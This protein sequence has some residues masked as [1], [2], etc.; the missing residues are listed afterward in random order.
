MKKIALLGDSIR[1]YGYGTKVPALLKDEYEVYQPDDNCRYAKYTLRALYDWDVDMKGAEIIHWN[2]GLWDV[3]N[4]YG[5]GPLTSIEDYVRDMLRVHDLLTAR[6]TK[7]IIFATCTPIMEPYAYQDNAR[8]RA[9]NE[10]VVPE[11]KKRGV[12]I[13]DLYSLIAQNIPEY[14]RSDD[15]IHLTDKGADAAAAQVI[16]YIRRVDRGE[17]FE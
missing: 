13:N 8:I 14:I 3:S 1:Y 16:D 7:K 5:D 2:N 6:Y 10:A 9:Y 11:L 12:V 17:L 15:R 4:L